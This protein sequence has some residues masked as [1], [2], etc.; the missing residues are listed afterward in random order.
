M[1]FSERF[2]A[3]RNARALA[4]L[5]QSYLPLF[6]ELHPVDF[7]LDLLPYS[8]RYLGLTDHDRQ[9]P[10]VRLRPARL[11]NPSLTYTIPH[12]LTHL[13]Q[14]PLGAAPMGERAC[15]L[16]AMARAG[17]RFLVPP[18]YLRVPDA[19]KT[20]WRRWSPSA[21][22]LAREALRQREEGRRTYI[23][24]WESSFGGLVRALSDVSA[25]ESP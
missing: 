2:L 23:G 16:H 14:R 12:E 6:P 13:I 11:T 4:D 9:P 8:S 1:H 25:A 17:L 24:W 10:R 19:A 18:G 5:T 7:E 22:A 21:T 20:D 3:H 15:D